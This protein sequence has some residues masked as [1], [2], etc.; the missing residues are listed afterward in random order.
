[1]PIKDLILKALSLCIQPLYGGS[2]HIL[3]LHRVTPDLPERVP[4]QSK[5]EITPN[6]LEEIIQFFNVRN[7]DFLSLD[8][9]YERLAGRQLGKK[10]VVF[11][12]DDG[13]LDNLTCAYPIFKKHNIPFA[14]YIATNFPERQAVLWWYMLD[15]LILSHDHLTFDLPGER[16]DLNCS[17]MEQKTLA[18]HELRRRIKYANHLN[19]QPIIQSIF[20]PYR[21]DLYVKTQQ[22]ALSW[23]QI[24]QLAQDP[25]VTI[26]S[27]SMN[28]YT[29]KSLPQEIALTEIESSK[30]L[31]ETRIARS[32]E[33]FAYPYG[34]KKEAGLRDFALVKSCGFKTAVTTRFGSIF[35]QHGQYL[36]CLP[37]FD[38]PALRTDAQLLL[39]MR[40]LTPLR[41]NRFRRV[42]TD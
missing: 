1:M 34:E 25:L 12:F 21:M 33:H 28:H 42:I 4:G 35:P 22:L 32:V 29:L 38:L 37:R 41:R 19:Y 30:R 40:G 10:F 27:H 20:L 8:Q 16:L 31:I 18:S 3:M 6:R 26:G 15:D 13:Y 17:T 14:V 5:L 24:A 39:A 23:Q 36:E 11:T 7:Y 9:L 2:G